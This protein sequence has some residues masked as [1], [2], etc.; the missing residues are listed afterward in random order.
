[1][2]LENELRIGNLLYNVGGMIVE[3]TP[4]TISDV[5]NKLVVKSPILI[6]EEIL[7]KCGFDKEADMFHVQICEKTE[8]VNK[9]ELRLDADT[10]EWFA[11]IVEYNDQL[12]SEQYSITIAK[13]KYL[14][15]LQNIYLDLKGEELNVKL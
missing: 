7:L 2:K 6:T 10:D 12:Q 1:M 14:H 4:Q 3:T 11:D 5:A 13:C 9:K 8:I 15:H